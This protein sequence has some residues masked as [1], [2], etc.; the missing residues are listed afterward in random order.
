MLADC[1]TRN[2]RSSQCEVVL[3]ASEAALIVQQ[4]LHGLGI[5]GDA[6]ATYNRLSADDCAA[7]SFEQFLALFDEYRRTGG[8]HNGGDSAAED[9]A[10]ERAESL[11]EA[12]EELFQTYIKDVIRKGYLWRRGYLLPT[13]KEYWFVLQPSELTFYKNATQRELCGSIVL[14][15]KSCLVRSTSSSSSS[16]VGNSS[17]ISIGGSGNSPNSQATSNGSRTISTSLST[18][19]S[20]SSSSSSSNNQHD[21]RRRFAIIVGDREFELA[22]ADNRSRLQCIAALQLAIT[23]S[24]GCQNGDGYQRNQAARRRKRRELEQR[25]RHELE[26]QRVRHLDEVHSTRTQLEQERLGRLAAESQAAELQLVVREDSRRVAELEDVKLT[27]ERLLLEET[28]AKHDEEIVRALQARVLAEEWE[29]RAEL[30]Q[31]QQEQRVVLEQEREKRKRFEEIQ[32]EREQRLRVAEQRLKQLEEEREK[33]DME[34]KQARFKMVQSEQNKLA[35]EK[36]LQLVGGD[37]AA[38]DG[39]G[40]GGFIGGKDRLRRALSFMH[41]NRERGFSYD[42][43]PLVMPV[44]SRSKSPQVPTQKHSKIMQSITN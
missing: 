4:L 12:V 34:L 8:G 13:L 16:N 11:S 15:A 33:L 28:R 24:T 26:M 43:T 38:Q 25:R 44:R 35:L 20:A 1:R 23:Y 9:D 17:N 22:A 30:E 7:L 10:S 14:D 40:G 27:L 3:D 41:T 39:S 29:K 5:D 37:G 21:K 19:S 31:L 2:G 6:D 18:T 42:L 36:R 32:R